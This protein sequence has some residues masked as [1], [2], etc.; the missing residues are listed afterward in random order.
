MSIA[1]IR[2]NRGDGYQTLVAFDWALTVLSD[3]DF[4]WI[5]IDSAMHSVDDVVIGKSD[6]TQI[7][8]Q[9][10]KNQ[11][12][13]KDWSI[14]NLADE[15]EKAAH[16]LVNDTNAQVRFYSRSSF[17]A[18]AKL[19]EHCT[20]QSNEANYLASLGKEHLQINAALAAILNMQTPSLSTYEFLRRTSFEISPELV[21]MEAL[22][23]ER[24]RSIASNS[25]AAFNALWTRLD[26]LG[27]RM[28][29]TNSLT[30]AQHRLTKDD[31]KAILHQAGALLV[32]SMNLAE[33]R[34][35]FS[36]TSAIGRVWHRNIA[37]EFIPSPIVNELLAAIDDNKH[38]I[39]LTGLPGSGKTCAMLLLQEAL[40]QRAQTSTD[41]VP[42]FI[43]SREFADLA[44]AQDRQAQGLP[45]QWVEK[46][47][48]M[49]ESAQVVVVI[50][51][52]DVLSIAREHCVLTYFLAQ[53][54]RLLLISNVTVVTACRDFD[55]HY[56]RRIAERKWDCELK[57]P[58]LGWDAEIEPLLNKL[59][60]NVTSIDAVTRELIK[61]PRELALFVELAQK[62]GSFN[63]VNS[64]ALARRYLD[65]IVR[66]NSALGDAAMQAI[67]NIANEMLKSRSLA[68]PYQRVTASDAMQRQLKSLNVLQETQDGKV[69]FGHQ[70]LLDVLVI[71][72]AIREG[73][74]L[75]A[76]IQKLPPVP[77]VRPSIRSFIAQ[78]A[79]GVRSEFRKQLRT[80][81]TGNEAFHIRR[82][83]AETFAEQLPQD[84]DW[85]L[86][87][88]LRKDHHEIFQ[89]IYMQ[90]VSV[91]W[92][93]FWLKHL[94]PILK[95]A[96]DGEMLTAHVYRVSQW[97]NEDAAGV[98]ALWM[99]ALSL[100]WVDIDK[101]ANQLSF[102]IQDF[103]AEDLSLIAPLL[104]KL[105]ALPHQE[106]SFLGL[107]ISRCVEAG[108]MDD[109][110]LWHYI[111]GRITEGDVMAYN[112]DNK[113]HC[114]PHEFGN[115]NDHFLC[116]RMMQ[117]PPLL[118]LALESFEQWS[119]IKSS[120]YDNVS[121]RY[122]NE[123]LHETS[124]RNTH[125]QRDFN[126]VESESILL[127]A[128][129]AAILQ[130]AKTHSDWWQHN[131]DRL[132]FN[133]ESALRYFAILACTAE[134]QANIELIGR[135]LCD[136]K[137]LESDL[138]YELGSLLQVAFIHLEASIQDAVMA[139]IQTIYEEHLTEEHE[140]LWV[141][142]NRA[143]LIV[144][145]PCH[146]RSAEAQTILDAYEKT[147]G[148]LFRQPSIG[149]RGGVVSAPFSFEVFLNAS[150]EC[151]LRLL[152][153]YYGYG[154]GFDDFLVGGERE[155]GGQLR[156]GSSRDPTRFLSMLSS[157]WIDI[158][159]GFRDDI[160][161]GVANYL[162]RRYGNL[163]VDG[164]WQPIEE[165][166]AQ[167][168]VSS[169]L[170][171]LEKHP[172]HWHLNRSTSE[173]LQ[174]CSHIIQD[175]QNAARLVFLA[176]EFA[177]HREE[178]YLKGD[179][180]D[181]LS[182]GINMKTGHVAEALMIMANKLHKCGLP[183]P[184]LLAPTLRRFANNEHPAIRALILRRL[185]YLQSQNPELGWDLF[186]L[187]MQGSTG[188][189]QVAEPCLYYAYRD[190]FEKVLPMLAR[191]RSEGRG[192]D[193]ETWGRI[194]ALAALSKRIDSTVWLEEL[195]NLNATEAWQG[196]ANVWTH[197]EN[198]R[199]HRE[200]CLTG[201]EAGL[202]A[203]A[204]HAIVVA[205]QIDH[206]FRD[207]TPVIS[208][209]SE[210][211]QLCFN[212]FM[213]DDKNKHHRLYGYDEW[214]NATSQID[215][216]S[217]LAATEIYLDYVSRAKPYLHDTENNLTQLITR[218]FTEAEEKEESDNGAMLQ[219]VVS[220]QD[221]F[222][223]LGISG[224]NEWLKSAERL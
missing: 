24:L 37:G 133:Q 2:S 23:S 45:E 96:Q 95:D 30:S 63:V 153:H 189:W 13:F 76:F 212:V 155:V 75:N 190:H 191:I 11:Q 97:K 113:L 223:S 69:T 127:D 41:M 80:V 181:L 210:L 35:A 7:C 70:T 105:L 201:I 22:L 156:E 160:I 169:I 206:I 17:G 208:L 100:N 184:E 111:A 99:E 158:S 186:H 166:D 43:Q 193:L 194:S 144:T 171:E 94:L 150:D 211:L 14:T 148:D 114:Q 93:Y 217:A 86:L 110:S 112:F 58:P 178:S 15:L 46:V 200:Q 164:T 50:D 66:A 34:T 195:K 145:I 83:V 188:L 199:P 167:I 118:N 122:R 59:N 52:L 151:V 87:R 143:D 197:P 109:N 219:R 152:A 196:A 182:T 12:D 78:L 198:I 56:D 72:S 101:I 102:Y 9:C 88:D 202:N 10:K 42:L 185:P 224:I 107:T 136:R 123:F 38:A 36:S 1:G 125:N 89:V 49:A 53:I 39:L 79:M 67:E 187:S 71:S 140:S 209:P 121:M 141:L 32:P 205:Q 98:I 82:L 91:E 55:R 33:V 47:A 137:L 162:A 221:K 180:V 51:S 48:R 176:I 138:Q 44:T 124:Y 173:A 179:S 213:M 216:E 159:K 77:F 31:L 54:D 139:T 27:A 146:L 134:P 222:L 170:E 214:L 25:N 108:S 57:C 104:D 192:K 19:R 61:N 149:M 65:T 3:P 147:H 157:H 142:K 92:H 203:D 5:E 218:L 115:R 119:R 207:N 128:M 168:L 129:E 73:I 74:T 4:A 62:E 120:R 60:I 85:P 220:L 132:S 165:P 161:D 21:R 154:R 163:Q 130:H 103:K 117:S 183:F 172:L 106:H 175:S 29:D 116:Q 16:L 28:S 40:E 177:N 8:C 6:G 135:M 18:I 26:Q 215:S 204:S 131:R 90:A 126:H 68:V 81:L 20:T 84:E 174:A 64:Q